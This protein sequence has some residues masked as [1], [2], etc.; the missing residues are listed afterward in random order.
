LAY[1]TILDSELLNYA[2]IYSNKR[3]YLI[4]KKISLQNKMF[5]HELT[6]DNCEIGFAEIQELV[7]VNA[8]R[9]EHLILTTKQKYHQRLAF[10]HQ[11]CK[12]I[13]A[14]SRPTKIPQRN[15]KSY[16]VQFHFKANAQEKKEWFHI[17]YQSYKKPKIQLESPEETI[18]IFKTKQQYY[19][20]KQLTEQSK[21]Y[22][23]RS[24]HTREHLHPSAMKPRLSRAMINLAG[25]VIKIYDP[26]C[27][28]GG[29]I[30]EALHMS[31]Q[32]IGSDISSEMITAAKQ[33]IQNENI[34]NAKVKL[35]SADATTTTQKS[36]AIVSDLPY[37][38]NTKKIPADLYEK[39]ILNFLRISPKLV[40]CF[41]HYAKPQNIIQKI[42]CTIKH[43]LTEYMH[44]SLT[45]EIFVIQR[46]E[47]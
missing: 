15:A 10:C 22:L 16:K 37:G 11:T 6:Q 13:K 23:K 5:I 29:T 18:C 45:R 7:D 14:V 42:P 12:V 34:P 46:R 17:I 31:I 20:T 43:H 21:D 35:F 9:D 8:K 1:I 33:N 27:G 47:K 4:N 19:I 25:P 28:T 3:I 36:P 40:L 44:K 30:I 26:C 32:C 2:M 41:P 38:K 24:A 39:M